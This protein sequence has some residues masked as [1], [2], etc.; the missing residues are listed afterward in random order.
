MASQNLQRTFRWGCSPESGVRKRK[1]VRGSLSGA[2]S[3]ERGGVP[4]SKSTAPNIEHVPVLL[5]EASELLAPRSCG[6]YVDGTIG[7]GGHAEEILKRSAPDGIL[8]GFDQDRD[9]IDRCRDRL[10]AYGSRVILHHA[11]FREMAPLL[12][13]T[14]YSAV[15]G[16]LLDLGVSWFHLRTPERGFSFQADGPLDMRMDHR[17]RRTAADLVN[18]LSRDELEAIIREYGE[19]RRAGAIA[20]A[21]ERAR[22]RRPIMSTVQLA[23][24]VASAFPSHFPRRIHPSTLTF[25]ALRIV[26]NDELDALREGIA[27]AITLLKEGGRIAVIS[28]H[29]LED[30]IVKQAF[31]NAAKGCICPPKLPVCTCGRSPQLAI[32]TPR[33]V[34]AGAAEVERNSAARS[35]KLRAA[36]KLPA[37]RQEGHPKHVTAEP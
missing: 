16:V 36:R 20:R 21:I 17:S 3:A 5:E 23:E 7:A 37:V 30:R 15:D 35:A 27:N 12:A 22:A 1:T 2:R 9:A 11:N 28:F 6:I 26:V 32:L 25:Q 13:Q 18:S 19:E 8:I 29:S 33:P 10:A 34:V 4:D 14:G 24:I 31:A